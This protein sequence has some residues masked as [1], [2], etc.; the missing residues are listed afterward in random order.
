MDAPAAA[1]PDRE[2][3][4]RG[5]G[6]ALSSILGSDRNVVTDGSEW[7]VAVLVVASLLFL[8]SLRV[9]GITSIIVEG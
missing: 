8:I 6:G 3:G 7:I 5:F 4:G 9:G 2:G 1:A